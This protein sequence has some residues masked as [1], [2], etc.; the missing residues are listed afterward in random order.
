MELAQLAQL[1][2]FVGGLAVLV[3]LLYL[4]VQV[5]QTNLRN[6]GESIR[7]FMREYNEVLVQ[8]S[9]EPSYA[10]LVRTGSKNFE[11]LSRTDQLRVAAGLER[12]FRTS[13]AGFVTDPKGRNPA[14]ELVAFAFATLIRLPGFQQWWQTYRVS[15][16]QIAPEYVR[17]IDELG[18]SFPSVYEF[19]P[20]LE[21]TD[22]EMKNEARS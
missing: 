11:A 10:K 14:T 19:S 2:E 22:E 4:A 18:S 16:D 1:G 21:P 8:I 12:V 3:T 20:W 15:F 17:W 5:R 6:E 13:Y 9:S 7:A